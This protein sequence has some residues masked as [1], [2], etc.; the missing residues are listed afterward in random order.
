MISVRLQ[1][2]IRI[3]RDTRP[4]QLDAIP[5]RRRS[6]ESK[7]AR[8]GYFVTV[9]IHAVDHLCRLHAVSGRGEWRVAIP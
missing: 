6:R 5:I 7:V 9:T 2:V 4:I 3:L 1:N 8:Y